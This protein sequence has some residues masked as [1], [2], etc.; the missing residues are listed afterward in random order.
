MQNVDCFKMRVVQPSSLGAGGGGGFIILHPLS[1][2]VHLT[3]FLCLFFVAFLFCLP[4]F[5]FLCL[6]PSP[7]VSTNILSSWDCIHSSVL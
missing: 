3:D 6:Y 1:Y 7:S 5:F 4:F 2:F